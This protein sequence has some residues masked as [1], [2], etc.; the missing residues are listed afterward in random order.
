VE[1]VAVGLGIDGDGFY[2][3]PAGSLDDPAGDLA[4]I[5]DQNSFEH[6]GYLQPLGGVRGN[7]AR[8]GGRNNSVV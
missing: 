1:G 3:H 4:P 2:S 5:R 7:L 6:A 8:G